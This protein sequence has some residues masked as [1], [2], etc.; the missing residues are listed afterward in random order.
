[1]SEEDEV[2][3]PSGDEGEEGDMGNKAEEEDEDPGPS[4]AED[5]ESERDDVQITIPPKAKAPSA[6]QPAAQVSPSKKT[7]ALAEQFT[8]SQPRKVTELVL[9]CIGLFSL[10]LSLL[11]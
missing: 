6:S 7:K 4:D 10:V 11:H 2:E 5:E 9:A 1:M 3:R 8:Q